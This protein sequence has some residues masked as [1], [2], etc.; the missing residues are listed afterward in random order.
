MFRNRTHSKTTYFVPLSVTFSGCE[1]YKYV[2]QRSIWRDE[3]FY[4]EVLQNAK[5]YRTLMHIKHKTAFELVPFD[6]EHH[7]ED[8]WYEQEKSDYESETEIDSDDEYAMNDPRRNHVDF[9]V[10]L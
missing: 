5:M 7:P 4:E 6:P 9:D 10:E 8:R 1:R 2:L 3:P